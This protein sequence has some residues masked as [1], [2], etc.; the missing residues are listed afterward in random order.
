MK[1]LVSYVVGALSLIS[2]GGMTALAAPVIVFNCAIIGSCTLYVDDSYAAAPPSDGSISAPYKTITDAVNR[3]K[4][5]SSYNKIQVAGGT[6]NETGSH[7]WSIDETNNASFYITGG[8]NADFT[9]QNPSAYPSTI[10]AGTAMVFKISGINGKINGFTIK[11]ATGGPGSQSL[12][13]ANVSYS[14]GKVVEISNNKIYN[15]KDI[16]TVISGVGI[17]ASS[18]LIL[19]NTIYDNKASTSNGYIIA[20]LA[21]GEIAGNVIYGNNGENMIACVDSKVYNNFVLDNVGTT[22]IYALGNCDI[23]HNTIAHNNFFIGSGTNRTV[24]YMKNGGNDVL[25]NMLADNLTDSIFFHEAGDTSTFDYNGLNGNSSDPGTAPDN[26]VLCD[27]MF[28]GTST[29]SIEAHKLGSSSDCLDTGD[30][31]SYATT[32]YEGLARPADGDGD[33]TANSDPGAYEAAA[34]SVSQP[35]ITNASVTIN[36]VSPNN[37]GTADTTTFQFDLDVNAIVTVGVYDSSGSTEIVKL[38]DAE[39]KSAGKVSYVWDGSD[40]STTLPDGDYVIKYSASNAGGV[41]EGQVDVEIKTTEPEPTPEPTPEEKCAGY[42][43]VSASNPSCDAIEYVQ[44]IGAM[45]G[46]PDGTFAPNEILQRDQ[47]AK[48]SL[49]TFGLFDDAADYCSSTNP[50]PDVTSSQWS[51]QYICRGVDIGMITGYESGEDAGYYRPARQVNRVEFLALILRNVGDTMPSDSS[52]S[53]NDVETGQWFSGYAKYS[54]DNSLFTGSN[55]YPTQA[56]KRSEVA[57]VIYK[58]HNLGKI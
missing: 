24:V 9:E 56:T 41:T 32:D 37:D 30:N 7:P 34:A 39:S 19:D 58:L 44:S 40:G 8:Y 25:N 45:T 46:N 20:A 22:A 49:E 36:P 16:G 23:A 15:N 54:M 31:L 4:S 57:D 51:F 47:V 42:S 38:I 1:K 55:L 29:T 13:S 33:G 18:V 2:M 26:N 27:P 10:V 5:S 3:L 53:Y 17:G 43:D 52:T 14:S 21:G 50:F 28:V 12:I 35:V 11:D 6:Y 48:I